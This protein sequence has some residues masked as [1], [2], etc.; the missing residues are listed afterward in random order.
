MLAFLG[1]AYIP[2]YRSNIIA[3]VRIR[4]PAN[5]V[6]WGEVNRTSALGG[7]ESAVTNQADSA[8]AQ[9]ASSVQSDSYIIAKPQI[10]NTTLKSRYD[11]ESYTVKSGDTVSSLADRFNV[12]SDSIRWS[13]NL[14]GNSIPIGKVIYVLPGVNGIIHTVQSG[15]TA[16][17]LANKYS[18][19]ED[20]IIVMNDAEL[21]GLPIGQRIIIPGGKKTAPVITA[22]SFSYYG[23]FTPRYGYN[24]Y[25]YGYCT[26]YVANKR[27]EI[28]RA[29][30]ANLGDAW[31]WDDLHPGG[32]NNRPAYGAVAVTASSY[33]PGHV[34]FVEKV[35]SDGSI[36]ISEMNSRGQVSMTD[37]THAGGWG[38]V[39]YKLLP[40]SRARTINYIH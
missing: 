36:W 15:D 21:S 24:G 14:N 38:R 11:I 28:G 27:A 13:N 29:V 8:H 12:T 30:P 33:R 20:Q 31:T 26:W 23:G 16:A 25:D 17:S 7:A 32:Y 2:A 37:P 35:N 18:A 1:S 40:A 5:P 9:L 22:R 10:L 39:D 3:P 19:N 6:L 34:A 4:G